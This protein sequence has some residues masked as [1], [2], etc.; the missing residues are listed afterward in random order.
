QPSMDRI[1]FIHEMMSRRPPQE[2]ARLD[3]AALPAPVLADEDGEPFEGQPDL[4]DG[5][6]PFDAQLGDGHGE[7]PGRLQPDGAPVDPSGLGAGLDLVPV[8]L[9]ADDLDLGPADEPG[10]DLAVLRI[11]AEQGGVPGDEGGAAGLGGAGGRA[12]A[13]LALAGV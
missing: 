1:K 10:D 8:V 7:P 2:L 4:L 12:H 5:P 9:L 3:D 11:L 6:E 13:R